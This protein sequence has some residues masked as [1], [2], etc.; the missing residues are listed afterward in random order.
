LRDTEAV[1]SIDQLA[2]TAAAPRSEAAL[3][4]ARLVDSRSE[5][6]MKLDQLD[7]SQRLA[8]EEVARLSGE[9][10][11]LE[12]RSV[13]GE[14]VSAKA[15]GSAEVALAK[16]RAAHAAP[17]GERRQAINEAIQGHQARVQRFVSEHL[18]VL[19]E[20][21]EAAGVLA[22]EAVDKAAEKIVEAA[23]ERDT[24]SKRIDALLA[25]VNGSSKFGDVAL[26]RGDGLAREADR[27]LQAGGEI[28]PRVRDEL[29]SWQDLVVD[30]QD[31]SANEPQEVPAA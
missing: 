10:T 31:V 9:L 12:R 11:A 3:E 7:H 19:I 15:L 24:A 4:L 1:S 20:E 16:A 21:A 6:A 17:W 25:S 18:A 27:L 22:A 14:Q 5:L 8:G 23:R 26:S 13:E 2:S 28:A 30:E 29:R